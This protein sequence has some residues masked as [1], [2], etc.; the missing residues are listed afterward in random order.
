[1]PVTTRI[2]TAL[3]GSSRKPQSA[4]NVARRPSIMWNGSPAIQ[5]NWMTSCT[6]T[7]CSASCQTAPAE[8]RNES[9]TMPGQIKLTS[10][11]SGDP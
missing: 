9:S 7:V 10:I 6:R 2:I 1:M 4:L 8:S 3:S 11:F 5:V